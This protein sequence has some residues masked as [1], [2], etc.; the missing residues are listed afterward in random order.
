MALKAPELIAALK[1][2]ENRGALETLRRTV[3]RVNE[4]MDYAINLGLIDANPLYRVNRVFEK[5]DAVNMPTIRPERLP[6]LVQRVETTNLNVLTRYLIW[7]Q[8]LTLVRPGE[9]S[10]TQWCEIDLDKQLWTIPP[11]RMKKR[12]LHQVPLSPEMLW[13]LEKLKSVRGLS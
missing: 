8:L 2:I 4:V 10:G 5:P 7:W 11:E 3:Q 9:A 1:P 6:E 13:V 12:R